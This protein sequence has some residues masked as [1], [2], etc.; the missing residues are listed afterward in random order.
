MKT[1]E[2]TLVK[3]EIVKA[4]KTKLRENDETLM[5]TKPITVKKETTFV[6]DGGSGREQFM[7][8]KDT[9]LVGVKRICNTFE[10]LLPG[11]DVADSKKNVP[12]SW[13]GADGKEHMFTF[14]DVPLASLP[15]DLMKAVAKEIL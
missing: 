6:Y 10:V 12:I 1:T 4:L 7:A 15:V 11:N 9:K 5:F 14:D 8:L 3:N 2:K 13:F